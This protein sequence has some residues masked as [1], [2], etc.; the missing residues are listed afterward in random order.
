MGHGKNWGSPV[1]LLWFWQKWS[2]VITA[3]EVVLTEKVEIQ[4]KKFRLKGNSH[5]PKA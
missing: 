5:P 4:G 3:R 2:G 1:H